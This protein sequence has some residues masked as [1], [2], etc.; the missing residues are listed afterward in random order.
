MGSFDCERRESRARRGEEEGAEAFFSS[1]S[2]DEL[3]G[4]ERAM[5]E[6]S[7]SRGQLALGRDQPV[8]A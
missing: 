8:R 4:Y 6:Q 2:D 5:R 3:G 1:A 7:Q